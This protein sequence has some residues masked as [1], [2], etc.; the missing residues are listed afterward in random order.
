[1]AQSRTPLPLRAAKSFTDVVDQTLALVS[2]INS[3]DDDVIA[4]KAQVLLQ[5][6]QL[7]A[8]DRSVT[9]QTAQINALTN[10]VRELRETLAPNAKHRAELTTLPDIITEE[11]A[12]ALA[13]QELAAR[14]RDSKRVEQK[15]RDQRV[16]IYAMGGIIAAG[17]VERAI[18]LI[19]T[20]HW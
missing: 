1:M 18:H 15:Q 19:V 12:R 3:L 4:T 13:D 20:G 5:S 10:A 2:R 14:R 16:A 9:A 8:I 6:A 7:T 11:V 17:V